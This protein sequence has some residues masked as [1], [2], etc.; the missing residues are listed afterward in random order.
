MGRERARD[1]AMVQFVFAWEKASVAAAKRE[2]SVV[3]V[4]EDVCS[5]DGEGGGVGYEAEGVDWDFSSMETRFW[6]PRTLGTR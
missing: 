1:S 6:S 2:I 3:L 5:G 4:W